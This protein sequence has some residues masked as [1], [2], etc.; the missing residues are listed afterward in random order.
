MLA[1]IRKYVCM[2]F[3]LCLC[4]CLVAGYGVWVSCV[5]RELGG[6]LVYLSAVLC[7]PSEMDVAHAA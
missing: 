6:S 7:G 4:A 2:Q 1:C 5:S 3:G